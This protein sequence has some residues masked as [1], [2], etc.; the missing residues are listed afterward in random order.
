MPDA[1]IKLECPGD[2][3][4]WPNVQSNSNSDPCL[5]QRHEAIHELHPRVLVVLAN[6]RDT[7]QHVTAFA[8]QVIAAFREGSRYHGYNDTRATPQLNYEIAKLV[9]MRDASSQDWPNDWPT[10]GNSGDLSFVYEGLFTQ[11]F[12]AHYG[13][14]DLIDPSRN[15][16]LCELFEHGIINEV[17]I[18][19]PRFNGNPLG[20][21]ESKARV[22]VYDSNSNPLMGQFDNCAANGCYDPG[23]AGKCKV[24]VRFMELATDRGPGCGTHATGHGLEGL[25]SAIPSYRTN[26][27]R[28]FNFD[29]IRRYGLSIDTPYDQCNYSSS[30]CWAY[31]NDHT[32]QRSAEGGA[33]VPFFSFERWGEGCGNVHF[34]PN[35][36]GQYAYSDTTPVLNTCENYGQ[37]NGAGGQDLQSEYSKSLVDA[38]ESSYGDCGGGWQI[39]MRQSMPGYGNGGTGDEGTP[40]KSWWPYLYY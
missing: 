31:P 23:I 25:R 4:I 12:A 37:H 38:Y 40:M 22:Q 14:R 39:Y 6:N 18:A 13:Y 30:A 19:A 20:V 3:A 27:A 10:T 24:S 29:L 7:P 36:P 16:T 17:W 34:P 33:T 2:Y 9:D 5:V 11:N 21:Y 1:H 28:F 15:L 32:L 35:A 8:N 26:S